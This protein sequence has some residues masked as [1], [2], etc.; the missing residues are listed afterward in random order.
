MLAPR[1]EETVPKHGLRLLTGVE[2]HRDAC[3]LLECAVDALIV[4]SRG[5]ELTLGKF[6]LNPVFL[7]LSLRNPAL[8]V[9]LVANNDDGDVL[10]LRLFKVVEPLA[11]VEVG[12]LLRDIVHDHAAVRAPIKAL[13]QR[14][15]AFLPS[16]VPH[17]KADLASVLQLDFPFDEICPDGWLLVFGVLLVLELLE[18]RRFP[19]AGVTDQHDLN[20]FA[21][22][23]LTLFL[24]H[25]FTFNNNH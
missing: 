15:V 18:E 17:L 25:Y 19:D 14:L 4:R 11:G 10:L 8:E 2:I 12:L 9:V 13:T 24:R 6:R 7:D 16:R 1:A 5:Q 21:L 22:R 3:D 20:L 23:L